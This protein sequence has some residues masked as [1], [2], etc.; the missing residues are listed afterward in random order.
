MDPLNFTDNPSTGETFTQNG[1]SYTYDGN[2][3]KRIP[4]NRLIEF[5]V[6]SKSGN[7]TLSSSDAGKLI[8]FDASEITVPEN[9][10]SVGQVVTI[11]SV[12]ISTVKEQNGNVQVRFAGSNLTGDRDLAANSLCSLICIQ[13]STTDVFV[14]SG[15]G[16][17]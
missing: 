13:S 16:I 1:I 11:R 10:F 4:V 14:I 17:T 2:V 5:I 6:E 7:H 15:S 9:Q 3:W 8:I 12:G